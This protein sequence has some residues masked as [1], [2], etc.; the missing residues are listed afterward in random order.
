VIDNTSLNYFFYQGKKVKIFLIISITLLNYFSIAD[1]IYPGHEKKMN[2]IS[3]KDYP[4]FSTKWKM[5]TVRYRE[6]SEEMRVTYAN[7][8]AYKTLLKK[9]KGQFAEYPDGSV[10][11]K[12]G[13]KT[14]RDNLFY[15]SLT[16]AG[17]KRYQFMVR[18]KD[19]SKSTDGWTYALFDS[20]GFTFPGNPKENTES[21]HACHK[22]A[23]ERDYIFSE[24][25]EF[26]NELK[27][28]T[29]PH[30]DHH[31]KLKDIL[32]YE[33]K[34]SSLPKELLG[35]NLNSV[36]FQKYVGPLVSNNFQGTADEIIPTLIENV[37]A[38][39]VSSFY[40]SNSGKYFSLVDINEKSVECN[41][42]ENINV[43]LYRSQLVPRE[44]GSSQADLIIKEEKKCI[45]K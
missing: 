12:I 4:S 5:V 33:I 27:K 1:E 25:A 37:K 44:K 30:I 3:M 32:F 31:I 24:L 2:G 19:K 34:K 22:I 39:G 38:T 6:D 16:P 20:E 23:S 13:I 36:I 28:T 10:F 26:N 41:T 9:Q 35:L 21:C 29:A 15:S 8:L 11:A 40:N 14:M 17:S 45:K 43:T 42:S 18:N 7:N